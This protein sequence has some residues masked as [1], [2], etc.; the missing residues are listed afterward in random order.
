VYYH[1]RA[2]FRFKHGIGLGV[3]GSTLKNGAEL[4]VAIYHSVA[5]TKDTETVKFVLTWRF[6]R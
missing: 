6:E 4:L 2:E 1:A 3:W 5:T